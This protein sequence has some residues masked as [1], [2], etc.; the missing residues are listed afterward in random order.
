MNDFDLDSQLRALP[1]PER[2]AEYWEAFP[3]RVLVK[4]YAMPMQKAQ[5][6]WLPRLALAGG[7]AFACLMI[8]LCLSPGGSC[9][10]K[11]VSRATQHVRS[12]RKELAQLSNGARALMRVDHGL[13]YLVEEQP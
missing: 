6:V 13:K 12:F 10:L 4:A 7:I 11:A 3:Q 9:P 8:G 1:V 2:D 5:H